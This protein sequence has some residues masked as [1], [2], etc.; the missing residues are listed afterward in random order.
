[1]T[2]LWTKR[3]PFSSSFSRNGRIYG[4]NFVLGVTLVFSDKMD[5]EA[6]VRKVETALIEKI[7]SRDLSM[8]VD[9]LKKV[10]ISDMTLLKAFLRILKPVLR[11]AKIHSLYLESDS[12]TR[13][14]LRAGA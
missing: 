9:F 1:M 13:L 12:R 8:H 10:E 6:V 5:E 7:H 2:A 11:P 3:F 4:R 14:D